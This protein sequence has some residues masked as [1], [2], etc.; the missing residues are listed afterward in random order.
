MTV[1]RRLVRGLAGLT[2]AGGL[3]QAQAYFYDEAG[4]SIRLAQR[5]ANGISY[6]YDAGDNLTA[7]TPINLPP[8]PTNFTVSRTAG[9]G[10]SRMAGRLRQRNRIRHHAASRRRLLVGDHRDRRRQHHV[11]CRHHA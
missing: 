2:I 7:V 10:Q 5:Q 3:A 4:T 11:L 8:A 6:S 1:G 9:L